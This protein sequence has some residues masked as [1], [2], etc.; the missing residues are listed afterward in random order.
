MKMI[1]KVLFQVH[2]W[3]GIALGL[4]VVVI[5]LTGSL[6]VFR[7]EYYTYFRPGTV[8]TVRSTERLTDDALKA[9]A[10]QRYPGFE[11]TGVQLRRRQRNAS[12]EVYLKGNGTELRR[13]FDP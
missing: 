9:A 6:L 2:L 3:T 13:L 5:C 11:V 8:V 7:V 10:A 4:Y 12:A 1:R